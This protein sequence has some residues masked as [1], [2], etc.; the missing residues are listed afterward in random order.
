VL[1]ELRIGVRREH[2]AVGVDVDAL[3]V[4]LLEQ[5]LEVAEVMAGDDDER[6]FFNLE[7]DGGR[8]GC[9]VSLGVGLV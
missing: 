3:A 6:A 8:D 4:R 5:E 9:A 7:R 1:F 2:F